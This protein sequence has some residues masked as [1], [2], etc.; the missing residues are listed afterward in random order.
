MG[1]RS[2]LFAFTSCHMYRITF[3]DN[4]HLAF[5]TLAGKGFTYFCMVSE[6]F[7]RD[8]EITVLTELRLHW[9]LFFVLINLILLQINMTI[10]TLHHSMTL[11]NVF[12]F[13]IFI[14][15]LI[16]N[17]T[18]DN[19]PPAISE[20]SG[21]FWGRNIL[22]TVITSLGLLHQKDGIPSIKYYYL[23]YTIK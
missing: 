8:I 7:N 11:L 22:S 9:T 23:V 4:I 19:I 5:F 20:M 18:I 15:W 14:I 10:L 2:S 12:F 16:A 3:V 17:G 21:C 13:E 6:L 1:L